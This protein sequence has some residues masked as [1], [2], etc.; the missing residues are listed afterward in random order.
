M[1]SKIFRAFLTPSSQ[2]KNL[3]SRFEIATMPVSAER[4]KLGG[5]QISV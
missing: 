5:S 3:A 1:I 2:P 4:F